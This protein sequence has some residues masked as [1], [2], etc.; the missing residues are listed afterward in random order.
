MLPNKPF[1]VFVE[2]MNIFLQI[3]SDRGLRLRRELANT[4]DRLSYGSQEAK[5]CCKLY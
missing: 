5:P 3:S 2:G 4:K 1:S